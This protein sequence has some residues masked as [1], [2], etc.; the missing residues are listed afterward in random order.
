MENREIAKIFHDIADLLDIKGGNPFRSR[1]YRNAAHIIEGLAISL[2]SIVETDEKKLEDIPG[3]GK[4]MH[5][6]IVELVRTGRCAAREELLKELPSGLLDILSISGVGHKKAE[7]LYKELG[8]K[9]VGGL[10]EAARAG[11]LRG[12]SGMGEKSEAKLI[13]A[14]ESYKRL[15]HGGMRHKIP[16]ARRYAE[17][18]LRY[19]KE[20]PEVIRLEAA[21]S[22]RRWKETIGD[23]D[24]LATCL[25]RRPAAREKSGTAA[26]I[27]RFVNYPDVASVIAEGGTKASVVLRNGL[28][29]DLRVVEE[30]SFGAALQY[31]TGGK[32]HNVALRERAGSRGLKLSEYGVFDEKGHYVAGK[33]EEDVYKALG[34]EWIP[35]ELRENSGEIEAAEKGRL[36][37]LV[38]LKDIKGDLHVHTTDSDGNAAMIDIVEAAMKIGY[39]YVAVTDHS[40]AVGIARGMD[41]ERLLEQLRRVDRLNERLEKEGRS[42]R[43]LKGAEVDIKSDGALDY[44]DETLR[45]LDIAVGAVHSKFDMTRD[46]MTNRLLKAISSGLIHVLA[47]PTGRL[48]G[49]REPYDFDME[50][51]MIEA[52]KRFVALELN[53][54]PDRLDLSDS[55]CRLAKKIGVMVAISTD[56][57]SVM[58]LDYMTYGVRI[59]RRG[60]LEKKD[61][62]NCMA[63]KKLMGF[64]KR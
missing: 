19:M 42:F 46:D 6:K 44:K 35:P 11:R 13:K 24:I 30:K 20:A 8:I 41:D 3:I 5:E 53:A 26:I 7:I 15:K 51:V 10:E 58:N 18:Y 2:K 43:V 33:T 22:L 52:S 32:A 23:I 62:L 16:S 28:Q 36:P 64:L 37:K 14:I 59:A 27:E 57:H 40:K 17:D 48:V 12:L 29:A 21:G 63:L 38:E 61:V 39:A 34:L 45:K 56:S 49:T 54:F 60:W 31:F 47:H 1:S 50:K 9:D 55:H 4:S 25:R